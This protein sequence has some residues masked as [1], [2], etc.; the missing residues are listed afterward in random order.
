MKFF[1]SIFNKPILSTI[2]T[3]IISDMNDYFKS[4]DSRIKRKMKN[5]IKLTEKKANQLRQGNQF[6]KNLISSNQYTTPS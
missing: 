2:K 5:Q 1:H 3:N 6:M 4:T